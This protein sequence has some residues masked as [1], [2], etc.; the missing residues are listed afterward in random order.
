MTNSE[1]RETALRLLDQIDANRLQAQIDEPALRGI[2][3]F[4]SPQSPNPT[5]WEF[6]RLLEALVGRLYSSASLR[7]SPEE[8]HA[9]GIAFLDRHYP[10]EQETGSEAAQLDF[11]QG[12]SWALENLKRAVFLGF[13]EAQKQQAIKAQ[14]CACLHAGWSFRCELARVLVE[15]CRAHLPAGLA[16][17]NP[18]MLADSLESLL[19]VCAN[20]GQAGID[21]SQGIDMFAGACR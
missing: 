10:H 3:E 20:L 5:S 11:F 16:S 1:I 13:V 18:T 7:L 15:M 9:Q 8:A 2:A 19:L 4:E 12:T 14:L 21:S 6:M 17:A